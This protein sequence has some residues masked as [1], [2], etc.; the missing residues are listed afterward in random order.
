MLVK[1][2]MNKNVVYCEPD[3]LVSQALGL[4]KK[5]KIHQLP[6]IKGNELAGILILN[7]IITRE[8]DPLK[9][10]ISTL[11]IPSPRLSP[12]D[13]SE[14]AV[15]LLLGS[16]LRAVPVFDSQLRGM[17]SE[18]DLMKDVKP[19]KIA[20]E[21]CCYVEENSN[22]GKVKSLMIHKNISRVPVVKNGRFIGVVG[23]LDLIKVLEGERRF[24]ARHKLKDSG[25]KE[26]H[27]EHIDK[28]S[29]SAVMREP[30]VLKADYKNSEVIE[31]LKESEEVLIE[32]GA[33]GIITAKDILRSSVK[34]GSFSYVQITGI[35]DE[36]AVVTDKIYQAA[37]EL[38][39][40][41]SKSIELQPM[42]IYIKKHKKLG[43][44][45][46]YSLHIELPTSL[47]LFVSTKTHGLG[48]TY[49]DLPT[50]AQKAMNNLEREIRKKLEKGRKTEKRRVSSKR[51]GKE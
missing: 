17:I 3:E 32:N 24:E 23:T 2:L 9:T 35:T 30:V 45:T 41:L 5:Y 4:M 7:K 18:Q 10:K 39:Q 49:A 16:N 29:V 50:L 27:R 46:N 47:G 1:D 36:G 6:V 13:S 8:I 26:G 11:M 28:I 51:L 42:K 33:L 31:L 21:K 22:I 43:P 14:D 19:D 34:P 12:G 48:K 40:S 44:K 20:V 25:Y 38:V 37:S 15:K